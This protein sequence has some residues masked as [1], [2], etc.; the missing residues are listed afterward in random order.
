MDDKLL[1]LKVVTPSGTRL[2]ERT[3]YI[4]MPLEDGLIGIKYNHA[5]MLA[6]VAGGTL[7][8]RVGKQTNEFAITIDL[9]VGDEYQLISDWSWDNQLGYGRFTELDAS[10]MEN[11]GGFG[12]T[13]ET[14][15]VKVAADGKYT[16]TL[17]TNPDNPAQIQIS[18]VR[19]SDADT[20]S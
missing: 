6:R 2:S 15:N 18:V 13:D 20:K 3:E 10:Q 14:A 8:Y 17:I 16:I 9:F 12:G 4:E 7:K 1:D 11:A 5:P 19:I